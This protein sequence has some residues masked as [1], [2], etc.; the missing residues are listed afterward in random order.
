MK[1]LV[2]AMKSQE[3]SIVVKNDVACIQGDSRG[4]ALIIALSCVVC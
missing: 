3:R 4:D 2:V 1:K